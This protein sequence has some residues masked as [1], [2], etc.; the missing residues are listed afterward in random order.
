MKT[1]NLSTKLLGLA[2]FMSILF[3]IGVRVEHVQAF[4]TTD[5]KPSPMV[6]L[7]E[8]QTARLNVVNIGDPN[9]G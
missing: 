1:Q 8:G 2:T 5:A 7:A 9:Q 6:G 4:D 3:M